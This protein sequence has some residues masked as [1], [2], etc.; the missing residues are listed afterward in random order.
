MPD[1]SGA[2]TSGQAPVRSQMPAEKDSS[3]AP[4]ADA[5]AW[6]RAEIGRALRLFDEKGQ[7]GLVLSCFSAKT[8]C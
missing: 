5:G 1:A 6:R 2:A 4:E 8:E 7:L 3:G